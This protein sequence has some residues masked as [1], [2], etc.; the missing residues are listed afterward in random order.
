MEYMQ[1]ITINNEMNQVVFGVKKNLPNQHIHM[2]SNQLTGR[3]L[4]EK[5]VIQEGGKSHFL[6]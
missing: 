4:G 2:T 3:T 1:I 6:C 5:K